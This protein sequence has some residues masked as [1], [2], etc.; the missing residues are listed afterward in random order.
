MASRVVAL[1]GTP[2]STGEFVEGAPIRQ[3]NE[4]LLLLRR[5]GR[6]IRDEHL[7][8]RLPTHLADGR[9]TLV[10]P[11]I[12]RSEQNISCLTVH[13]LGNPGPDADMG[14]RA[15]T[16]V[17]TDPARMAGLLRELNLASGSLGLAA[18]Y[19][20]THHGPE[21][22]VPAFFV[23]IGYGTANAPPEAAVSALAKAIL[24]SEPSTGDRVAMAVGGG[25][26]APH[27][28]DLVLRRRWAVGHILS[29]HALDRVDRPT[30]ES[31]LANSPGAEG[32]LFARA[33]DADH[34]MMRGLAPRKRDAEAE[35]REG[36]NGD[37]TRDG[38]S[39]S[40]T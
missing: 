27:F 14:G 22:A 40:G 32:I 29:R 3:L 24:R 12:H 38:R 25:H 17:P 33:S 28:S 11:S 37:A 30:A 9:T 5:P 10:F 15:R 20:A 31:M 8:Q 13:P 19:E 2:P 36:S 26:Y 21:L 6:H 34:P 18:T 35:R 7:E 23:E 16:V 4:Q 39:T 1:W